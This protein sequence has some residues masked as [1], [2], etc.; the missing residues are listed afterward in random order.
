[1]KN[2]EKEIKLDNN[3]TVIFTVNES[4]KKLDELLWRLTRH[5]E[6]RIGLS[7]Q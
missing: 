7:K 5:F 6:E 2:R 4:K 1:M 3:V